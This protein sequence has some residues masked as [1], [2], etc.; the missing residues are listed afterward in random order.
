VQAE[1]L[2][3]REVKNKREAQN[4]HNSSFAPLAGEDKLVEA[5]LNKRVYWGELKLSQSLASDSSTGSG[6]AVQK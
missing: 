1:M 3:E 4:R 6:K 2:S 5:I